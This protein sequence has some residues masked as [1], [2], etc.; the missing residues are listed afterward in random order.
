MFRTYYNTRRLLMSAERISLPQFDLDELEKL[1]FVLLLLGVIWLM[2]ALLYIIVSYM[3]YMD[4]LMGGKRL[5][6]NPDNM[7][8]GFGCA[9]VGEAYYQGYHQILW[10]YGPEGD[11]TEAGG[12]NFFMIWKRKDGK[13]ELIIAL[14]DD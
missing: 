9:K 12:S 7:V 5:V 8:G 1:I 4:T 14:L 11:Y 3:A 2:E 10:L 6:M 13:K